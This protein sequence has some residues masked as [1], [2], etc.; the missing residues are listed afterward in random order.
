[1]DRIV[2]R[3]GVPLKGHVRAG[4]SKNATLAIMAAAA[5]A[6]GK[7][8][9]GNVPR[10]GDTQTMVELLNKLG[11][12]TRF[13]DEH[14]VT[15]DAGGIYSLEAPYDLVRKMRASFS[16]LGPLLARFGFARVPVPGGCDIGTRPVNFHIEGLKRLGA[17]IHVEHGVYT[18]EARKL[19]GANIYLDFP[20]AGATQHLMTAACLAEG[21]TIIENC[22]AEPEV[23]DLANFLNRLGAQVSGAGTTTITVH[24]VDR[25]SGGSYSVISDRMEAGTYAIAAAITQGDIVIEN[26]CEDTMRPVVNKL[27]EA[28]VHVVEVSGGLRVW[29]EGRPRAVNIKTAP[30]PGF[31]TDMQ[32]PFAALLAVANGTSVITE[33]VYESRF[34]YVNELVRMGADISV[35]GRTAVIHGVE[36]LTGAEVSATD[37][38][39]G[40]ALVCAGL[41]AEGETEIAEIHH[42]DRGYEDLVGKLRSLGADISRKAEEPASEG[43]G[44]CSR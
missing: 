31:P 19:T 36:C 40:A 13:V 37:L 20:S 25:L 8:T 41:A 21:V 27:A 7:I 34:R 17:Q 3:G 15:I 35:E 23:V 28:G 18:A 38:R 26:A 22:A 29:N 39:A 4:G 2:V 24:G 14:T 11:A 12:A 1:M 42:I 32:Q 5:L 44:A 9:L 6:D 30:H 16:V 10:I 33:N 43:V